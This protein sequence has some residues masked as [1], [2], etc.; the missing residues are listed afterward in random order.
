MNYINELNELYHIYYEKGVS[1]LE[2]NNLI[3]AKKNFLVAKNILNK[4]IE[5]SNGVLKTQRKMKNN[6]LDEKINYLSNYIK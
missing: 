3:E 1:E 6:L 4:M 5:K 2:K